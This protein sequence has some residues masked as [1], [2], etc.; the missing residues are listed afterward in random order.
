MKNQVGK[1]DKKIIILLNLS[2]DENTPI[3]LG[4]SNIKHMEKS[5]PADYKKYGMDIPE[6][7]ATPDYIGLNPNDQSIEYVKEY[8]IDN[9][10]VKV[11]VRV[12]KQGNYYARS[13][14]A[15]NNRRVHNFIAKK[16]LLKV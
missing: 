12:S 1:I 13:I 2:I 15:L 4:D 6:I 14:Y 11:A 8:R 3:Y 7:L 5:H 10:Y 9:E 16:T